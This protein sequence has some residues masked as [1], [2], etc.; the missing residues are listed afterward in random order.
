MCEPHDC[1]IRGCIWAK[2]S[3]TFVLNCAHDAKTFDLVS[4]RESALASRSSSPP[5]GIHFKRR[6][7]FVPLNF[8]GSNAD[9]SSSLPSSEHLGLSETPHSWTNF[10]ITEEP[11]ARWSNGCCNAAKENECRSSENM[12]LFIWFFAF[13]SNVASDSDWCRHI[14]GKW[15]N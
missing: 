14:S 15:I 12:I 11:N 5:R 9:S 10:T 8:H 2:P 13:F 1:Q 4:K 6:D 7:R 3:F